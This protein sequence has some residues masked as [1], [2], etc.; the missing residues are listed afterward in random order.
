[1][2]VLAVIAARYAV[3]VRRF[4]PL[5]L[6]SAAGIGVFP[7]PA[8]AR[9][10]EAVGVLESSGFSTVIF[11]EDGQVYRVQHGTGCIGMYRMPGHAVYMTYD[12]VFGGVGSE[13]VL[14]DSNE[15]CMVFSVRLVGRLDSLTEPG[16]VPA[17]SSVAEAPAIIAPPP[18]PTGSSQPQESSAPPPIT[19]DEPRAFLAPGEAARLFNPNSCRRDTWVRTVTGDGAL[20]SLWDNSRWAIRTGDQPEASRW[21]PKATVARCPFGLYSR[22]TGAFVEAVRVR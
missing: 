17:A 4:A 13:L 9:L 12:V 16:G 22:D 11:R 6:A 18:A 5:A 2:T 19:E 20:V 10:V 15:R 14:P 21:E 1:V 8:S 3:A 7:A